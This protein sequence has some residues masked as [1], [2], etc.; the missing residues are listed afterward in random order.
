MERFSTIY[1][2]ACERKGGPDALSEL[3]P[4]RVLSAQVSGISDGRYLSA[5]SRQVFQSGFVWRVVTQKWPQYE[6]AF[7]EF[8]PQKVVLLSPE[9]LQLRASDPALIR[10]QKKTQAI[11]DNAIMVL[12]TSAEY[13]S[14][15]QFISDWPSDDITGLWLWLKQH[16]SRLGGNT[17]PYALR[18]LGKDTFLATRDVVGYFTAHGLLDAAITSK[19]GLAQMQ[20][21]FNDWQQQTGYSLAQL[22]KI[23]AY[24]VGEN[25]VQARAE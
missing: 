16:G 4:A 10:H 2:R 8:E 3:L 25:Q 19:K 24:S 1:A 11:Y 22:S 23:V 5:L 13:G 17:G 7:F 18:A 20:Q 6:Q 15:G 21:V 12:E 14:F 9:Q